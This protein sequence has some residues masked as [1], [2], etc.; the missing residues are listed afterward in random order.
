MRLFWLILVTLLLEY[1]YVG[2]DIFGG[3]EEVVVGIEWWQEVMRRERRMVRR[4]R[5]VRWVV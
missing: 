2:K 1:V 5:R 4:V 3:D